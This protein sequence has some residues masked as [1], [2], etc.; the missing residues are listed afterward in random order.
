MLR[1]EF[2][3]TASKYSELKGTIDA[4]WTEIN[5]NYSES[6]RHYHTL[7]HLKSF[8]EGLKTVRTRIQ[9]WDSLLFAMFYH[10]IIYDPKDFRNEE[11]SAALAEERLTRIDAPKLLIFK[12]KDLILATKMHITQD[13]PDIRYFLDCDLSIL[14]AEQSEYRRYAR[15]IRNEYK[16]YSDEEYSSGR[17]KVLEYFLRMDRIFTSREFFETLEAQARANLNHELEELE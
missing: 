8:L 17:K 12:V 15:S 9:D 16:E 4:L 13:D 6:H 1:E 11:N 2:Y 14:G 10:D 3:R 7:T 5:V